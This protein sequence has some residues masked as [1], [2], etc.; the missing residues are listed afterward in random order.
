MKTR[1]GLWKPRPDEL[2]KVFKT[3]L[4]EGIVNRAESP[5]HFDCEL[6]IGNYYLVIQRTTNNHAFRTF[7]ILGKEQR[8]NV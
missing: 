8:K 5:S 3:V 4:Y 6:D 7:V 2:T 1:P